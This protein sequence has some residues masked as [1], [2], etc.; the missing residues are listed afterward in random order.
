[1]CGGSPLIYVLCWTRFFCLL[2][3]FHVGEIHRG[4]F[5]VVLSFSPLWTGLLCFLLCLL[6]Q[7]VGENT[8]VGV[9]CWYSRSPL[10]VFFSSLN[11]FCFMSGRFTGVHFVSTLVLPSV[12]L[13]HP[14]LGPFGGLDNIHRA[15]IWVGYPYP[16]L[17]IY[18][19]GHFLTTK[20]ALIDGD[21]YPPKNPKKGSKKGQ[22]MTK[23][24][25]KIRSKN[26]ILNGKTHFFTQI[27]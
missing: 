8:Q 16:I 23:N 15:G 25:S 12:V 21:G 2:V 4:V 27:E 20:G 11:R 10:S 6:V 13:R 14:I 18:S 17:Y 5:N 3:L 9:L 26:T 19:L 22:K 24:W 7:D 1:M